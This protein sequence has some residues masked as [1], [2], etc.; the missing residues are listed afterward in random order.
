MLGYLLRN[1]KVLG[2]TIG[3]SAYGYSFY[4]FLTQLPG[5][6]VQNSTHEHHAIGGVHDD[7][8]EVH[9]PVR[10]VHRRLPR[11]PSHRQGP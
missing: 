7:S 8:V 10:P 2:L 1:R 9:E 3:F 5:Y 6:L 11:R 4:L